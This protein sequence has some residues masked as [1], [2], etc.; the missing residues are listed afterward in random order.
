MRKVSI[1]VTGL[2]LDKEITN[3]ALNKLPNSISLGFLSYSHNLEY[4]DITNRDL[5]MNI[6][7]ETYNYFFNGSS[8]LKKTLQGIIRWISAILQP[9]CSHG[10]LQKAS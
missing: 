7:M 4:V 3:S 9:Q 6:P 1:L 10:L 5:L 8:S 2:G